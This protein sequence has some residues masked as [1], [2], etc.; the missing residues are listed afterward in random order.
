MLFNDSDNHQPNCGFA[1]ETVAYLYGE[2]DETQNATLRAHMQSCSSCAKELS[3][4]SSIHFSIQNWKAAEFDALSSPE[5]KI[6]YDSRQTANEKISSSWLTDLHQKFA[7]TNGWIPAGAVAALLIGLAFGLYFISFADSPELASERKHDQAP[8][9][10]LSVAENK[11]VQIAES[12][13]DP[14]SENALDKSEQSKVNDSP[15]VKETEKKPSPNVASASE[16]IPTKRKTAVV[17]EN[18]S[19]Q[20]PS[21]NKTKATESYADATPGTNRNL[22]RLNNLPE[23]ADEED[24]RLADLLDEIDEGK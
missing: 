14:K 2:T 16:K 4:F 12:Q 13:P 20:Q 21:K 18:L 6:P 8:V 3:A 17:K 22:P 10:T 11:T 23:E 5:I 9:E 7:L 15:A 19:K 24:L 1:E